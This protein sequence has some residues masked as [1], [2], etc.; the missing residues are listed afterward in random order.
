[1]ASYG[2]WGYAFPDATPAAQDDVYVHGD[3]KKQAQRVGLEVVEACAAFDDDDR[4]GAIMELLD[5]IHAAETALRLMKASRAE[6]D[7]AKASVI[8]KNRER[9]Y[10]M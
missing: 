3:C 6:L 2:K 10:Y 8:T 9:G 4:S 5:V 1:M 7:D